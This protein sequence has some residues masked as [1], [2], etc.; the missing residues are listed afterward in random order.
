MLSRTHVAAICLALIYASPV[1]ASEFPVTIPRAFETEVWVEKQHGGAFEPMQFRHDEVVFQ[2]FSNYRIRARAATTIKRELVQ[3][4]LNLTCGESEQIVIA[5]QVLSLAR[6]SM[7]FQGT[8]PT[9]REA[10]EAMLDEHC[11]K[12]ELTVGFET[13]VGAASYWLNRNRV[14]EALVGSIDL[15]T[16]DRSAFSVPNTPHQASDTKDLRFVSTAGKVTHRASIQRWHAGWRISQL[17]SKH[18]EPPFVRTITIKEDG[19]ELVAESHVSENVDSPGSRSTSRTRAIRFD[20]EFPIEL[21]QSIPNGTP[22][23][24]WDSPQI[25]AVWMDGKVVRVYEG[26]TVDDLGSATFRV[27]AGSFGVVKVLLVTLGFACVGGA[28]LRYRKTRHK[29]D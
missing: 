18:T 19:S 14:L 5:G 8:I 16:P 4:G 28:L 13:D 7:E 24:L 27:A 1:I 23:A 25:K 20:G 17:E 12:N 29:K 21:T 3:G 22:V 15:L 2:D 10:L 9:T 11:R 6:T 26:G